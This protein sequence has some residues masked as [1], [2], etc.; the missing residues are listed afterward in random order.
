MS[1]TL[2]VSAT[3]PVT[4]PLRCSQQCKIKKSFTKVRFK[5]RLKSNLLQGVMHCVHR[6]SSLCAIFPPLAEACMQF[7]KKRKRKRKL[8][9]AT[10]H[11]G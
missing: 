1:R 2:S 8:S 9:N 4:T 10:R 11:E 6:P 7:K 3:L 5:L